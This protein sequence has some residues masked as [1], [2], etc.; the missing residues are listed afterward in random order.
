MFLMNFIYWKPK[1][2]SSLTVKETGP[3]HAILSIRASVTFGSREFTITILKIQFFIK[4]LFGSC[5]SLSLFL[6]CLCFP[7]V[8][9]T[10]S[11]YYVFCL[12][13]LPAY[14]WNSQL[15]YTTC[16]GCEVLAFRETQSVSF[17]FR[18]IF[19]KEI[20]HIK[21][22]FVNVAA[23]TIG[24]PTTMFTWLI[25]RHVVFKHFESEQ[26]KKQLTY[27][28]IYIYCYTFKSTK[29]LKVIICKLTILVPSWKQNY[30]AWV[31]HSYCTRNHTGKRQ[32]K[33]YPFL[34]L[35]LLFIL[36]RPRWPA[37]VMWHDK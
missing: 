27:M 3:L 23:I 37:N 28:Y 19:F 24:T 36:M 29:M 35:G 8:S 9:E 18:H 15:A 25:K 14:A 6:A 26:Y 32:N 7:W 17:F 10:T 20:V 16:F 4:H 22:C 11:W 30:R 2:F 33:L 5:L 21:N 34:D 13:C 31:C 12:P 1:C